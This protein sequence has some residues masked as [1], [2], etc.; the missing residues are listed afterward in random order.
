[1]QEDFFSVLA[2]TG[3]PLT[4]DDHFRASYLLELF[5]S[6]IAR[7]KATGK[8]GVRITRF[9]D[10]LVEE[11]ALIEK[12]FL[13]RSYRFTTFKE[14]LILRG[15]DRAP[16][17]ISIP[18]VR[19][20]LALRALCQVV[21]L[22]V[23]ETRGASPHALVK[24]V[25]EA[26]QSGDHGSKVFVRIDVK[27]FFPSVTHPI[28]AREL[29]RFDLGQ[30]VSELCM[31]AVKTRTG[32]SGEA[33][34]RGIPQGLSVSGAL[35]ALYMV[36]FDES[37]VDEGRTYFRY[38]DD[39]LYICEKSE[40]DDL[41][42]TVAR[43]L[44]AR[45]LLI[46]P[47]GVAGKTEISPVADGIDFLGYKICIENVSI[48]KSSYNRMFKNILKVI[49]NYKH[50]K[51]DIGKLLFRLNIKITGCIVD[52]GRR[53]W[54][55]FF[56]YTDD[57]SQLAFLDRFVGD[58]LK[59]AGFPKNRMGDVKKFVKSYHEIRFNLK[60]TK[61]IPNFDEY[62][63]DQKGKI[64]VDMTSHSAEEVAGW[65]VEAIEREFSNIISR[66]VQDLER[67]VGNIS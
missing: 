34:S 2:A 16:R 10:K 53:G 40:A 24:K 61:Y 48:R 31:A 21:H 55:M 35:A 27:D 23:P 63:L 66:E 17:Q 7:S 30:N 22:F 25:V 26:V 1:M 41:L 64:I 67:D 28:L 13:S 39:I 54:M 59:R 62:D 3:K 5:R 18:T 57:V 8:D 19:D 6:K 47:K 32:G 4:Q 14:R 9:Q 20:R 52:H 50:S 65:G 42:K 46:H 43:K 15:P 56:S 51:K 36:K 49:T 38:V 60:E 58:Q 12:R 11:A 29:R 45:G 37:Q 44:K 33:S